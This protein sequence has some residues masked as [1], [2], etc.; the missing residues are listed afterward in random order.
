MTL[1]T[2]TLPC[3]AD[4]L[5]QTSRR[6]TPAFDVVGRHVA[7]LDIRVDRRVDAQHRHTGV[8]RRLDRS[9]HALAIIRRHH[10]GIRL[11]LHHRIENRRLQ[12]L[13]E[14]LRALGID[15]D[16]PKRLRPW[17]APRSPS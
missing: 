1:T 4:E 8:D 3:S 2:K 6:E 7:Q 13:I 16:V 15:R 5:G 17:P 11:A 10:D 12:R 9:D 14:A